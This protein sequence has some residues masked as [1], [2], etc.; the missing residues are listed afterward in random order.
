QLVAG[1]TG[2]R[3]VLAEPGD[4]AIDESRIPRGDALVIEAVLRK[5]AD[6]VILDQH[7]GFLREIADDLLAIECREVDGDGELA[8]IAAKVIRGFA[9]VAP[10][11]V[12]E[13]R[14]PPRARVVAG[15]RT[16]DLDDGGA[17]ISEQLRAPRTR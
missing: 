11:G 8:A 14:R 7:V 17:E 9:R 6:F 4:R 2:V 1:A 15:V 10:G 16:L 13:V 12:L 5:T 3:T